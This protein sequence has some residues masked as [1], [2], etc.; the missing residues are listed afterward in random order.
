M[1]KVVG[2]AL[3]GVLVAMIVPAAVYTDGGEGSLSYGFATLVLKDSFGNI[4]LENQVHNAVLDRG[5]GFMLN[6]T[7]KDTDGSVAQSEATQMDGL[8]VGD[9]AIVN[10][11]D[12]ERIVDWDGDATNF[13]DDAGDGVNCIFVTFTVTATTAATPAT[14]FAAGNTNFADDDVVRGIAICQLAGDADVDGCTTATTPNVLFA[15][16]DTS[17]V[18]VGAGETVDITYTLTLD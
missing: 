10:T 15:V 6:Q 2:F 12:T 3:L 13:V 16:V 18:T 17:D 1:Y 5:T 9:Q 11:A 14:T 4:I 8:C 7:F